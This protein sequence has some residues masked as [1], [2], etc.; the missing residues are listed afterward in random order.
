MAFYNKRFAYLEP[1][2]KDPF[3]L[4]SLLPVELRLELAIYYRNTSYAITLTKTALYTD[5]FHCISRGISIKN[6]YFLNISD[7]QFYN[8]PVVYNMGVPCP[9]SIPISTV[10][11]AESS[12]FIKDIRMLGKSYA[13]P[14]A[15]ALQGLKYHKVV[16]LTPKKGI[17]DIK[18][19]HEYVLDDLLHT[20]VVASFNML[21]TENLLNILAQL[22]SST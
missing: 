17:I 22:N 14:F 2:D 3:T 4:F 1:I 21:V 7:S 18:L 16:F 10:R 5:M 6:K 8:M 13:R 19:I 20:E 15:F 9:Y 12:S 11:Y